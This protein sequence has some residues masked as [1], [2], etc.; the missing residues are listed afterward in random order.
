MAQNGKLRTPTPSVPGER[1]AVLC[2]VC[3]TGIGRAEE[4]VITA[5]GAQH[6]H[7]QPTDPRSEVT[8]S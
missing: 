1:P 3:E 2:A 7:C 4:L 8:P 5:S 6:A